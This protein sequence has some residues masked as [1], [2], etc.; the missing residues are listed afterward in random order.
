ML[1]LV[2]ACNIY[3]KEFYKRVFFPSYS[4][5]YFSYEDPYLNKMHVQKMTISQVAWESR[6]RH[7]NFRG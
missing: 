7:A 2:L 6:W 5:R 4:I 3:H 1:S